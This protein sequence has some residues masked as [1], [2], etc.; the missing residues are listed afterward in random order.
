MVALMQ[1]GSVHPNVVYV[2]T[3]ILLVLELALVSLRWEV[4]VAGVR[5]CEMCET[6]VCAERL[7]ESG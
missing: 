2:T 1:L 6:C 7:M 4:T 5:E 3:E